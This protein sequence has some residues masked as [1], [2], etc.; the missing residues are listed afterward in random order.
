[1]DTEQMQQP[2]QPWEFRSKPAWQRLIVMLGGVTVNVLLGIFIFWML[3]FRYG[4]SY[5]PNSEAKY[6]IVAYELAE[7]IGLQTGDRVVAINGKPF[8]RFSELWSSEV[9]MGNSELSIIRGD[10]QLSIMVPGNFLE[11]LS[12]KGR[13]SYIADAPRIEIRIDSLI[14]GNGAEKAGVRKGDQVI[15]ADGR[16]IRFMDELR[17]IL[18]E[19]KSSAITLDVLR[20][21]DTL[22]L[23]VEVTAEGTIGFFP[24]VDFKTKTVQYGFFQSL[25]IG[26]NKAWT[27]LTDNMK[28]LAKVFKGEVAA[29]KAVAGPI[30][31]AQIYGSTFDWFK[32]WTLTAIL[33][34]ILAFM[35]ILPIPALDGGHSLFLLVEMVKGKP[36]SDKFMERAQMVGFVILIGIMIFAFGNDLWKV[37]MK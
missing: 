30:G 8:E 32:F 36:L 11:D 17:P 22:H 10:Q 4:E 9:L 12:D 24:L 28:G 7:Q 16:S 20:G 34:M 33:S 29:T 23:P 13:G 21:T 1:M 31:I 25:P 18:A 27:T 26:A 5:L 14:A 35:N 15:G 37:F 3:T 6:G 19:K 2:A